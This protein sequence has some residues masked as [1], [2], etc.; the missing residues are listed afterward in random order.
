MAGVQARLKR[1]QPAFAAG[2]KLKPIHLGAMM[3]KPKPFT[4]TQS[5]FMPNPQKTVAKF[6]LKG[7]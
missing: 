4:G 3:A 5:K 2:P 1:R 6:E 7:V